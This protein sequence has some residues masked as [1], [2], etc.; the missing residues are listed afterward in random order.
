MD[1]QEFIQIEHNSLLEKVYNFSQDGYRLVQIH[2]TLL[3]TG[4]ELNYSFDKDN[5]FVNLRIIIDKDQEILSIS[6]IYWSAFLYEN[7]ISNLF[8][9]KIKNI[10]ID[11]N[12]ALYQNSKKA[13][14]A[15]PKPASEKKE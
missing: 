10:V 14:F 5:K 9:V 3:D 13:P 1:K 6:N 11:F 2:C 15:E 7:E 12:G 8:G 4:F